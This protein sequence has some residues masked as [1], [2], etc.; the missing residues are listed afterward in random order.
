MQRPSFIPRK[1]ELLYLQDFESI[2]DFRMQ[3]EEYIDYYN[4][5]HRRIKGKLKGMS[6][7]AFRTHSF[8]AA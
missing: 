6:P 8:V 3:L 1:S 5:R 4:N 7:V 2:E